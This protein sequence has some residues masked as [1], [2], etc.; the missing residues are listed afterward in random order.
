MSTKKRKAEVEEKQT[1]KQKK[2]EQATVAAMTVQE[3]KNSLKERGLSTNGTKD[4]L[5][6]RL[7]AR[8]EKEKDPSYKPRPTGPQQRFCKWCGAEM[9][10]KKQARHVHRTLP[11]DTTTHITHTSCTSVHTG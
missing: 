3:L 8:L 11:Q 9:Q 2:T 1:K 4:V 7:S 6:K 10:K 5:A